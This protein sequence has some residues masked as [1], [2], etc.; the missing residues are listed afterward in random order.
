MRTSIRMRANAGRW[1]R[2]ASIASSSGLRAVVRPRDPRAHALEL[3]ARRKRIDVVVLGQQH[4]ERGGRRRRTA[5]VS[6]A[7]AA[8]G[9]AS[10]R[11]GNEARRPDGLDQPAVE[12]PQRRRGH[13][14]PL[15]G[16]EEHQAARDAGG[17]GG[18][19]HLLRLFPAERAI[20]DDDVGRGTDR[21]NVERARGAFDAGRLGCRTRSAARPGRA[22]RMASARPRAPA[23][24]QASAPGRAPSHRRQR[25]AAGIRMRT[26]S[27]TRPSARAPAFRPCARRAGAK[28]R[29]R[30]PC[31]PCARVGRL[32]A[33]H[34]NPRRSSRAGPAATPAP[35]SMTSMRTRSP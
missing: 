21:E 12:M 29:G 27:P 9:A 20:D 30:G 34:G 14:A 26:S 18:G 25:R 31:P 8:A 35:V 7:C 13:G 16:R 22:P 11:R 3:F 17:A 33:L 23:A 10:E 1:P 4:V 2:P 24:P 32:V 28:W 19:R 5:C 15:E 6:P